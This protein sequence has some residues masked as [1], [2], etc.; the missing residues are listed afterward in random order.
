MANYGRFR[1]NLDADMKAVGNFKDA[2]DV[3][4][5]GRLSINDFHVGKTKK[6]DYAA[7]DTLKLAILELSPK[8]KKYLFDTL[9]LI[10]PY[11]KYEQYEH[12]D[13][14]QMMFGK[15]GENVK[16]ATEQSH[17]QFNL[18]VEIAHYVKLL[19]RNFFQSYYRINH[20]AI[21]K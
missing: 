13:N 4:A 19:A 6:E 18:V 2:Q 12:L 8:N 21:D 16:V 1:A 3:R 14:I 17:V 7:F 10:H 11:I 15:K 5:T 9:S 20:L